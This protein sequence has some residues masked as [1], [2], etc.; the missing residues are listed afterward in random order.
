LGAAMIHPDVREGMPLMPEPMV[1]HDGTDKN[2]G[3]RQAAKRFIITLRQDHPHL[4]GLITEDRLRAHAPPIE[5]LHAH[6]LHDILGVK[7]GDHASRFQQGQAAEHTGRVAYDERHDRA[8]GRMHRFRLVKDLPLNASHPD[9]RVNGIEYWERGGANVQHCSWV[10]DWRV[11]T[12]NVSHL[13]RGGRARWKSENETC[14]TLKN[15]GD[16]FAHTS[17]HGE[18]QRSVVCAM[19]MLLAF[20]VDQTQQRC[21]AL[22]QAVWVKLGRKRRRWERMRALLYDSIFASMRQ[23]CEALW[24]GC[25]KCSPILAMDASSSPS[26]ASVTACHRPR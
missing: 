25:K 10:T 19:L 15:Q 11:T 12:R 3:E 24:Y 16:H 22:F 4:K 26:I 2:D 23:L 13:M 7:D 20:L 17:G 21:C 8:A 9:V 1:Q 6:G 5:P 18:Q 14:H